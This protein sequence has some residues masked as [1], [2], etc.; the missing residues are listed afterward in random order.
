MC[1]QVAYR[2]KYVPHPHAGSDWCIYPTYDYTHCIID[3]IEYVLLCMN[4]LE[5][6]E[7][8]L[9]I[10]GVCLVQTHRLLDLHAGVR[11]SS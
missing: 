7:N 10:D 5:T 9:T 11:D 6:Y 3:S 1:L 8:V 4:F 2:I